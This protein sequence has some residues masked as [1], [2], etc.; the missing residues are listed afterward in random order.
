MEGRSFKAS[1]EMV[2]N[3]QVFPMQYFY[4]NSIPLFNGIYQVT[5]VKHT[6]T[7]NDM[8]TSAEGIR[9]RFSKGELAG[10]KPVTLDTLSNIQ[11]EE[12]SAS[13][14]SL[15]GR[16]FKERP[17]PVF[18]T[19]DESNTTLDVNYDPNVTDFDLW[20]Y[21]SWQQ[22]AYGAAEHYKISKGKKAN[23]G[24]VTKAAIKGNWPP[25]LKSAAGYGSSSV[26][27]LYSS[28][29]KALAIAFIDVWGQQYAQ[30]T[31]QALPKLN[32]TGKN[33]SGVLY[34]EIKKAFQKYE[35]PDLGLSWDRI[36]NFGMIEN[37]LNTDTDGSKTFQGM[38]QMNKG[39]ASNPNFKGALDYAK[40]GQ[41]HASGW[42]E[43]DPYKL[44]EKSVPLIL[45]SFQKF[46]N[47]SGY[48]N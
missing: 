5:E 4:L 13:P 30:K 11:V 22:G 46:V 3:A 18:E 38:F 39:Y 36:G 1:F 26:D 12:E 40:K 31:A 45:N 34:S 8:T 27:S 14:A 47:S 20:L 7:P 29:P 41:G 16:E 44:T 37:G 2:G 24:D 43:Y 17:Q 25:G 6:I 35:Q 28:N 21:L 33:R 23:Y 42:I 19:S 48:P 10:I 15:T 32:S 9:M